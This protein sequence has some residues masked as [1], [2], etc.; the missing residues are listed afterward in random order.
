MAEL[1]SKT[2]ARKPKAAIHWSVRPSKETEIAK[3]TVHRLFQL[4]GLRPHCTGSFKPSTDAFL[5]RS[6]ASRRLEGDGGDCSHE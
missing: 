5:S 4:F 1:I 2:L 3:S 6:P